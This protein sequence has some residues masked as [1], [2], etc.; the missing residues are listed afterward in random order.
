[1]QSLPTLLTAA[2]VDEL[3]NALA[4]MPSAQLDRHSKTITVTARRRSDGAT[5]KVFSAITDD[6][7]H[8]HAMAVPGLISTT[9]TATA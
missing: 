1:M 7:Q 4:A 9:M 3:A 8:W 5:V 2:Q 6:G